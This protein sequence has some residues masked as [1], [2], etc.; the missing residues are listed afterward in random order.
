M[1]MDELPLDQRRR[2]FAEV[3]RGFNETQT[4]NE[5][6]RCLQCG[7]CAQCLACVEACGENRAIRHEDQGATLMENAGVLIIADPGMAPRINGEDVIRAY[8]PPTAKTDVHAM[9][10]RGFAAAANAMVLLRRDGMRLKGHGVALV[11]PDP[12]LSS[13]IRIGVFACRCNS[14]FGWA[15]EMDEFMQGLR[16]APEVVHAE[17]LSSA[18]VAE[19]TQ[20]MVDSVRD[21]GLTRL[22]VASC[23]CCPLNF[24]CSACT[25]Q[26]S[27]LKRG[28]FEGTGIS[29]SMVQTCNLRGEVLRL[30]EKDRTAAVS[31]FKG[32]VMRSIGRARKLKPFPAPVRSYNFTTAVIGQTDA[33]GSAASTLAEAGF[34]VLMFGSAKTPLAKIPEKPGIFAFEGSTVDAVSGT[35]GNFQIHARLGDE[36][37]TF[38]V[39]VVILG[40]KS[41]SLA[42]Y[43]QHE[44][45]PEVKVQSQMQKKEAAGI[46][47]M[48][49]CTTSISGFFLADPP[50]IQISKRT[51]G[52]A[53][54]VLAAAAMPRGPRQSR[55]FSVAVRETLC[56]G[57]GRCL[58][59]CLYQ[60]VSLKKTADGRVTAVVD[61]VLCKGCGN[62]IS[63]CPSNAADSP[64]RDQMY[65]E[66]TLRE[67]LTAGERTE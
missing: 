43:R 41:R 7:G 38:S 27:R 42:I 1:K 32:I 21:Y 46:P 58:S 5:A 66:E 23:V 9:M 28:L 37:R 10:L 36:L 51:K 20:R 19:G 4:R 13:E 59:V 16:A 63:V 2:S 22:V 35:L 64:F 65:L 61:D 30:L 3:A 67:L 11:P 53:A 15:E 29:R 26:R 39:G 17:V 57:C 31:M 45:L 56:R 47:Y 34:E 44:D 54:A 8:G 14:S 48:V 18:C 25:D 60:A 24:V 33:A 55:G 52:E 40:E 12:G 62:C 49:P 50:G 6:A